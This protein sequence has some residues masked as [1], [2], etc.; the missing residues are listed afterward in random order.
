ML[1]NDI[2]KDLKKITNEESEILNGKKII[3]RGIYMQG[4]QNTVNSKKLLDSGK[5][6]TMRKHT[7]FIDFPKHTHDYVELVYMCQ[8]NTVH[9]VDGTEINLCKGEL[10]FLGQ[11]TSHSIERSNENDIA[12]NFIILP[13]FFADTLPA[14]GDE[15][16]P[17]KSFLINCLCGNNGNGYLYY[18]VSDVLEVQNLMENLLLITLGETFNK[19]KQAQMTM[20][21]L[22]M[23]LMAHTEELSAQTR[24]DAAVIKL[25]DYIETNYINGSLTDA[26]KIFH[27][28]IS[29]LSREILRKTGKTYTQLVQDKRLSQAAFLLKNTNVNVIDISLAV[30]YENVSYFH[31]K[32]FERFGMTPR[33]YRISQLQERTLF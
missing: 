16:T 33:D 21:L 4:S 5:L 29:W 15:E 8:G 1:K 23:Q 2:L 14:L 20:A 24:E 27:Y 3:N 7:R 31:R 11:G 13:Q 6:I 18:K 22:F 26:A 9:V 32:F 17:L 30:G 28:D 25:L 12:V 10:L 19:R